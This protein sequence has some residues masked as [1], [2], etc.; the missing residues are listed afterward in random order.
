MFTV[1][2]HPT[3]LSVGAVPE[4]GTQRVLENVEGAAVAEQ[5]DIG[6]K[7]RGIRLAEGKSQPRNFKTDVGLFSERS[8][9]HIF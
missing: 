9:F 1:R 2:Q 4:T 7:F 5:S 3:T 8:A 6:F